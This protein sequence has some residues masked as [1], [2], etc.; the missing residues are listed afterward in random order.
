MAWVALVWLS[1]AGAWLLAI[2]AWRL[3][4]GKRSRWLRRCTVYPGGRGTARTGAKNRIRFFFVAGF[5]KLSAVSDLPSLGPAFHAVK[6]F[7]DFHLE[8]SMC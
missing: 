3:L 2:A 7:T 4:L 1:G 5:G 8:P 6:N